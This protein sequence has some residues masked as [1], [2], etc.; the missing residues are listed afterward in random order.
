MAAFDSTSLTEGE[1]AFLRAL[2]ESSAVIL[3]G[4]EVR[5]LPLARIIVSKRAANRTKDQAVLPALELAAK[6]IDRL[7]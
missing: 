6:V 2:S 7:K 4:I 3:D 1:R 5:V